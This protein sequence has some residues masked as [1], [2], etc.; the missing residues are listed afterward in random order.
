[1]H[2]IAAEKQDRHHHTTLVYSLAAVVFQ[3]AV[4]RLSK[5][6]LLIRTNRSS[7]TYPMRS[8]RT[9]PLSSAILLERPR[10]SRPGAGAG[11][12]QLVWFYAFRSGLGIAYKIRGSAGS[13]PKVVKDIWCV[14]ASDG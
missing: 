2:G 1:M 13:G 12:W 10:C 9:A 3:S 5:I 4:S 6:T 8:R 7:S 14:S 11:A